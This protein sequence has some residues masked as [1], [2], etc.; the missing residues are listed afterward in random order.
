MSDTV[1]SSDNQM[2]D[3]HGLTVQNNPKPNELPSA[4]DMVI[5]DLNAMRLAFG[6]RNVG[7]DMMYLNTLDTYVRVAKMLNL[8][9]TQVMENRKNFGLEKYGTVLQPFNDRNQLA[10]ALDEFADALVYLKCAIQEFHTNN[11]SDGEEND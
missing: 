1:S 10:D 7:P 6:S 9:P 8:S 3:N 2:R 5:R 4:H 11:P